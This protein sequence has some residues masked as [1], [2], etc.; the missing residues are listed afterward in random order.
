MTYQ[1]KGMVKEYFEGTKYI[2]ENNRIKFDSNGRSMSEKQN[3][4]SYNIILY[5]ENQNR[6]LSMS[7]YQTECGTMS[8]KLGIVGN[9]DVEYYEN[10]N[11]INYTHY[12]KY[13]ILI[14]DNII[15]NIIPELDIGQGNN[16]ELKYNENIIFNFFSDGYN[17][18][19]PC[20]SVYVNEDMFISKE[21]LFTRA[22]KIIRGHETYIG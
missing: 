2:V 6:Y 22:H 13:N 9:S 14:N 16:I 4:P 17:E 5:N 20:G 10:D 7:F 12:V 15:E 19:V 21:E 11:D 8:G 3:I 18:A 1:I